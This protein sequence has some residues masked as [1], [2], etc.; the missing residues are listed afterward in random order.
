MSNVAPL[1]GRALTAAGLTRAA[2]ARRLRL[3]PA[4]ITQLF[5]PGRN[6]T[7]A[8]VQRVLRACGQELWLGL[9]PLDAPPIVAITVRCQCGSEP[10]VLTFGYGRPEPAPPQ[11]AE[12]RVW[13]CEKCWR[14]AMV[15]EIP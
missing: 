7:L 1:L 9:W 4:R 5:T 8:T 10:S 6:L 12:L 14:P 13:A 11:A 2:L 3:T 15:R